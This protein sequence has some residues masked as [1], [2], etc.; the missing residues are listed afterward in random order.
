LFLKVNMLEIITTIP[1]GSNFFP[2]DFPKVLHQYSTIRR[3]RSSCSVTNSSPSPLIVNNTSANR[4]VVGL[5]NPKTT[6]ATCRVALE[7]SPLKFPNN[8]VGIIGGV[9]TGCTL[10]FL[11]KLVEISAQD[12]SEVIPFIV[13]NYTIPGRNNLCE[14]RSQRKLIV[15]NLRENRVF[16]EKSGA[17]CI[18]MPCHSLQVWHGDIGTDCSVP[19]L[20]I[21]D[22]VVKELKAAKLKPIETGGN[23]RIG[24]LSSNSSLSTRF[25]QEK[26]QTE[27]N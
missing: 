11:N 1:Y 15:E 4:K 8:T 24:L 26:L 9:S 7:D 2:V 5:K 13:C 23:V 6:S 14:S 3:S 19:F 10:H 27:V 12:G 18:V 20:H 25:Y 17:Y 22:C 16:L 21:S